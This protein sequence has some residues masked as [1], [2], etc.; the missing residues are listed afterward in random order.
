[1]REL[2][3]KQ[4]EVNTILIVSGNQKYRDSF[5]IKRAFSKVFP[6]KKLV[7]VFNTARGNFLLKF[8]NPQEADEVFSNW[9]LEYLGPQTNIR[10]ASSRS[11]Q[12]SA[13]TKGVPN[14]IEEVHIKAIL[15]EKYPRIYVT[16]FVK[17]EGKILQTVKLTF[18][19][20]LQYSTA[21]SEGVF[22]TPFTTN[23][24]NLFRGASE[25]SRKAL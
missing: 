4:R 10:K 3:K 7:V 24:M 2:S 15:Q 5:E 19:S 14:D 25:V 16:R 20:E 12:K 23:H 11:E 21:I 18:Q 22:F 9:K 1:M 6:K 8:S 17:A 13:V